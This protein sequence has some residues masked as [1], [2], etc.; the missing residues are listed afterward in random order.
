MKFD[1]V[2]GNPPYESDYLTENRRRKEQIYN[3]FYELSEK[4]SD[5][6]ILISPARFLANQGGTP[7][8]WN[9]K[10]LND[11]YLKYVDYFAKSK[12]VFP[13]QEIKGGIVIMYRDANKIFGKI[14]TFIPFEPLRT[15]YEKVKANTVR[16]IS[17]IFYNNNSYTYTEEIFEDFPSLKGV[18]KHKG[19]AY[20]LTSNT[21]DRYTILYH[22][23]KPNDN[24]K[25]IAIY[26]RIDNKRVFKYIEEKYI[27][28]PENLYKWKVFIPGANGSGAIGE[29]LSTPLIGAPLI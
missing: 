6:Y 21:F 8:S 25:Y 17:D 18:V 16:N 29:V 9:K 13:N 19:D 4:I 27:K 5:K 24:K 15:A 26:G 3:Y 11:E 23:K 12:D 20:R 28:G 14:G 2:V 1:V 7:K 10:M 22:D